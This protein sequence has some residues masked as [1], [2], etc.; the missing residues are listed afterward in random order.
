[1]GRGSRTAHPERAVAELARREKIVAAQR[2]LATLV[3]GGASAPEVFAAIAAQVGDV[4]GLPLVVVWR[5][6]SNGIGTVVSAWSELAHPFE[7]GSRWPLDGGA[8]CALLPR[9]GRPGRVDD[10]TGA[11]GTIADAQR[12]SGMRACAGAPILVDGGVW[13]AISV[14]STASTAL[15]EHIEYRLPARTPPLRPPP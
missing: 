8:L 1:M 2:R 3:A 6:D 4:I 9:T 13:G 14:L 7:V 11:D 15:P 5:Y 10:L 12:S